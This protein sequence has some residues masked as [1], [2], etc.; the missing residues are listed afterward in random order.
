MKK[1]FLQE[2]RNIFLKINIKKQTLKLTSK[3][4]SDRTSEGFQSSFFEELIFNYFEIC[5]FEVNPPYSVYQM[6]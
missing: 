2:G 6:P 3:F 1:N 5:S 4:P